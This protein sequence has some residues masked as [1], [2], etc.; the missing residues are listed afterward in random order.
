[1]NKAYS[2]SMGTA[3]CADSIDVLSALPDDTVDLVVTSPPYALHFKKEYGNADQ[4]A[5]VEWISPF[6]EHIKRVL[7]PKGS[8]ALNIGG[9]WTPVVSDMFC[10]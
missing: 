9:A 10:K 4:D 3:Y 8:F 2:T 7:K 6:C 1:M 5:Y